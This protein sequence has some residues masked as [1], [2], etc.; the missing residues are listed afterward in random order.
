MSTAESP[1]V[2]P[3]QPKRRGLLS[4][5]VKTR[6]ALGRGLAALFSGSVEPDEAWFEEIEDQLLMADVGVGATELIVD[7]V[8]V[9]ARDSRARS[10]EEL[11]GVLRSTMLSLLTPVCRPLEVR[12]AGGPFVILMVGVNGVGKT[13]TVAKLASHLGRGGHSVM[14]AACDTYRAAAIE[15]LQSWGKRLQIPVVAQQ[16][17]ADPAAVAHDALH[18]AMAR[19]AS[20]LIVDTAGR[21][22]THAGLMEQLVKVRRVLASIDQAAPHET[23][24]TVDAGNGQN[25]LSQVEHFHSRLGLT[26]ICV[27]KLDGTAK[28]GVVVALA[29]KYAIPIRYVGTG[30]AIEDLRAFDA[31]EFVAALLP[32]SLGDERKP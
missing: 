2:S 17:G 5:L 16:H 12:A 13:T 23:L 7:A 9:A 14:V 28:G 8:R 20:V 6:N 21:Q 26:G 4:R 10:G 24:L 32:E 18:S 22:H 1:D 25:V 19:A 15:Q 11:L 31:A 29:E 30:E 3:A 27:T